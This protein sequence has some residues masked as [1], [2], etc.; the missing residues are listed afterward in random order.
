MGRGSVRHVFS[1]SEAPIHSFL[2]FRS[3]FATRRPPSFITQTRPVDSAISCKNG[4][5]GQSVESKVDSN[6]AQVLRYCRDKNGGS[7]TCNGWGGRRQKS[8]SRWDRR[9]PLARNADTVPNSPLK[10]SHPFI[11]KSHSSLKMC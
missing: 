5:Y 4:C 7:S 3:V 11:A 8:W 2:C 10:Y 6:M 9:I 1:F